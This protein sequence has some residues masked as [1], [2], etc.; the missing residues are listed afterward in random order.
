MPIGM[1]EEY[2]LENIFTQYRSHRFLYRA[3]TE[4][5]NFEVHFQTYRQ[6]CLPTFVQWHHATAAKYGI[7]QCTPGHVNIPTVSSHRL[8]NLGIG[9]GITK[10][11]SAL[12][13]KSMQQSSNQCN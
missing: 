4:C 10:Q 3:H 2:T 5:E 11:C 7:E 9:E 12:Q 6:E 1:S 8:L 13:S